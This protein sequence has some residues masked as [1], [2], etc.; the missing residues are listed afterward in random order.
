MEPVTDPEIVRH[1]RERGC[2]E[3]IWRG[4]RE[5]L[6]RRWEA[7]VAEVERGYP[8]GLDDYRDDLDTRALIAEAGLDDQVRDADERL[9]PLLTATGTRIWESGPGNPFWD[10]G[11]PRNASGE[12]LEELLAAR[13]A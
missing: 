8:L 1:L 4:G 12:L 9:R 3:H 11:Y 2:P 7:F 6:I 5:G 13:L 10:F